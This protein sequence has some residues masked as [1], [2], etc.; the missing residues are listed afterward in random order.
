M[1]Y[2]VP[3]PMRRLYAARCAGSRNCWTSIDHDPGARPRRSCW[4]S[5]RSRSL[6]SAAITVTAVA[7]SEHAARWLAG[8]RPGAQA[9]RRGRQQ[10]RPAQRRW[11]GRSARGAPCSERQYHPHAGRPGRRP[12]ALARHS[13]ARR[14]SRR[15]WRWPA[16]SSPLGARWRSARG[17][18]YADGA[19]RATAHA[20]EASIVPRSLAQRVR[21]WL[22]DAPAVALR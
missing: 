12:R 4:T 3:V 7:S 11:R 15:Q 17:A 14:R 2:A 8:R 13:A 20:A 21:R 22:A 6:S 19:R 10:P 16:R 18:A 9:T 1:S 5:P